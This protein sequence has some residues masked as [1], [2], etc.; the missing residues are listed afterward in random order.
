MNGVVGRI[1]DGFR[2]CEV[3]CGYLCVRPFRGRSLSITGLN[4]PLSFDSHTRL[5]MAAIM[6]NRHNLHL[7][8]FYYLD[9]PVHSVLWYSALC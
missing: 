5:S 2:D 3:P 4:H 1:Q 6:A 9:R 8:A 7:L